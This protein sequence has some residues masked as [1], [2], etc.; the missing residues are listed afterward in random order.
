MN[1]TPSRIVEFKRP[2][3]VPRQLAQTTNQGHKRAPGTTARPL[4]FARSARK[5]VSGND[6]SDGADL[7]RGG[8]QQGHDDLIG[9]DAIT[10]GNE[11]RHEC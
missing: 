2:N 8:T 4:T 7:H 5:Q 9:D 10:R 6:G 1:R 11:V 3:F